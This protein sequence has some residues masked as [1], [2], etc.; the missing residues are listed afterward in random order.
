MDTTVEKWNVDEVCAWIEQLGFTALVP[1]FRE[2]AVSGRDLFDLTDDDFTGS[3]GATKLQVKKIRRALDEAQGKSTESVSAPEVAPSAPSASPADLALTTD[4]SAYPAV[5]LAASPEPPSSQPPPAAVQPPPSD[6]GIP[7]P[8]ANQPPPAGASPYG[9]GAGGMPPSQYG[10]SP[11][12]YPQQ[13]APAP[14]PGYGTGM[15]PPPGYGT[16]MP[17]PPGYGYGGM[18]PPPDAYGGPGAGMPPPQYVPPPNFQN[19]NPYGQ[20]NQG[21][22]IQ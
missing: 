7:A 15:P 18:P 17:P 5:S 22:G 4:Q 11:P 1:K 3:L 8:L 12:G 20:Q 13:G 10:P 9:Y 6:Y 16:G 2:N 19:N 21:C 14:P